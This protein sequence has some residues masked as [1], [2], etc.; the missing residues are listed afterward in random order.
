MTEIR[1][2]F[3]TTQYSTATVQNT[4]TD[5]LVNTAGTL[6]AED[7]KAD[8]EGALH[9]AGPEDKIQVATRINAGGEVQIVEVSREEALKMVEELDHIIEHGYKLADVEIPTD[10]HEIS[11]KKAYDPV[12]KAIM[13]YLGNIG[14]VNVGEDIQYIAKY[15]KEASMGTDYKGKDIGTGGRV[16]AM[17]L[18]FSR[19]NELKTHLAAKTPP[20]QIPGMMDLLKKVPGMSDM[21]DK[22]SKN[23]TMHKLF[24]DGANSERR[25]TQIGQLL[26]GKLKAQDARAV[27]ELAIDFKDDLASLKQ[28]VPDKV[29]K[30]VSSIGSWMPESVMKIAAKAGE[31][32]AYIQGALQIM[33][34]FDEKYTASKVARFSAG[35]AMIFGEAMKDLSKSG[36]A[37]K[38]GLKQAA[39]SFAKGMAPFTELLDDRMIAHIGHLPN[40]TSLGDGF[41]VAN[42]IREHGTHLNHEH[43]H[44][45]A[46][47][48][49]HSTPHAD[50]HG[51]AE[52][53]HKP[54]V[55][56]PHKPTV[57]AP[58]EPPKPVL[59]DP[60]VLRQQQAAEM[61]KKLGLGPSDAQKLEKMLTEMD[62]KTMEQALKLLEDTKGL[63]G[64][65]LLR[66][67]ENCG[68]DAAKMTQTLGLM[69]D[70]AAKYGAESVKH[71]LDAVAGEPGLMGKTLTLMKDMYVKFGQNA[72]EMMTV[73][74]NAPKAVVAEVFKYG[75]AALEALG[76]IVKKSAPYLEKMGLKFEHVAPKL[77]KFL[78]PTI[79]KMVPA[80]GA[81]V[82]G[83][84]AIRLG[85]V[86]ADSSVDKDVRALAAMGSALNTADAALGVLEAFGIGNVGLPANIAMA[87]GEMAIDIAVDVYKEKPG[88]MPQGVR[89]GIRV[90]AAGSA[91]MSPIMAPVMYGI[92][93]DDINA[94]IADTMK[95]VAK[96]GGQAID[97]LKHYGQEGMKKLQSM[98]E[99]AEQWSKDAMKSLR[100]M[101]QQGQQLINQAVDRLAARP[102]GL[103]K[104]AKLY[105]EGGAGA[106]MDA[107]YKRCQRAWNESSFTNGYA[108]VRALFSELKAQALALGGEAAA[109]AKQMIYDLGKRLDNAADDY[110]PDFMYS[111]AAP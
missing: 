101:G 52:E 78:G 20:V 39:E 50:P 91:V 74:R 56:D 48:D 104:L 51:S 73:L 46:H 107:L 66:A 67:L 65:N 63:G 9:A 6:K 2:S 72:K 28:Y 89:T 11:V 93:K 41:A 27:F 35:T 88:T 81:I 84:D 37:E 44:H 7:I 75:N 17:A 82:A 106:V 4:K 80:L 98:V 10:G 100:S 54:A 92:Y 102:D 62:P 23:P 96:K 43:P 30:M 79:G 76:T 29:F 60:A 31:N 49:V 61:A 83:A 94:F 19:Y 25:L 14:D 111:W 34:S 77:G 1:N 90:M 45:G 103:G 108:G 38:L 69:K 3:T 16:Q 109:A 26:D 87:I 110:V 64:K 12:E 40:A 58:V 42:Q 47:A 71:V 33:S 70:I 55:D 24:A 59:P 5:N 15:L 32:S 13:S 95:W 18:A 21:I 53:P 22:L 86:A 8:L 97:A 85:R 57:E 68:G 99:G 105:K 36:L